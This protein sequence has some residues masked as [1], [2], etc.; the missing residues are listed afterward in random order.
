MRAAVVK[1]GALVVEERP[2]PAP[3]AGEM[4]V[5]VKAA[6]LNAADLLQRRGFYPAPPGSPPD[7]PG[8]EMAGEVIARGQDATRFNVGDRVMAVVGGGA[9]ATHLAVHERVL[10]P[11]PASVDWAAAGG[12]PEGF[13]T[14]HDAL[15]TQARLAMGERVCIHGAAGGVG[16]AAVQIAH[17]AGACPDR[18]EA[19]G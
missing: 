3:G 7:I 1:D 16:T 10:M 6:G 12:F 4:L 17:G 13:T 18:A 8:L 9:Q 2:D 5:A 19:A 14:A 11:V 15:F